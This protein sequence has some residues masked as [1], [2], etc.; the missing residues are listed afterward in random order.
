MSRYPDFD[1]RITKTVPGTRARVGVLATPHGVLPTPAFIF[2]ATKGAIKAAQPRELTDA[3]VDIILSNTYHM[4]L[5]PGAELVAKMGGLHR[6]S[7]WRGPMLTDSGG[8]QIFAFGHG[9][10]SEE[11]KGNRP[12]ETADRTLLKVEEQGA[13]FRAYTDGRKILLTPEDSIAIQQKLGADLI[14]VLDECTPFHVDRDY[15]QRSMHMSHRWG[16]RCLEAFDRAEGMGSSGSQALYGIVQGG[17]YEDLRHESAGF[18]A[19]TDFFG[20]AVG[21]CLGASQEQMYEV[22][23]FAMAGLRQ[24]RPT[25]LL[26][27]GGVRDIWEGVEMGIDTFDC[28]SP[29]R[30][31]RHGW[32][33]SRENEAFRLNLRNARF[34]E[35]EAPI[36]PACDCYGCGHFSRSYV[37]HLLKA[38]EFL[39][40]QLLTLHNIRFMTRLM[41]EIRTAILEG[42]FEAAKRA[43]LNP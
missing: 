24:D 39:G 35:D 33:L 4:M 12:R 30:I 43:W 36:D 31:A 15:T 17:V 25:H 13:T 26:G 3:N 22:V 2:C 7:G 11:I 18:V 21:G 34:R 10:V 38:G 42:R 41:A 6:F 5:Q 20:Q 28:V 29:T 16:H 19:E 9:S 40:L 8:Y 37:H 14:V 23:S 27:I 32:A 1:F